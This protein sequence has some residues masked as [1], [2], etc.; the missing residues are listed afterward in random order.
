MPEVLIKIG[1]G[2]SYEDGDILC[3]FNRRRTRQCHM[4]C[5]CHPWKESV[6][7]DGLRPSDGLA[8]W[9]HKTC[10]QYRFERVN[11]HEVLRTDLITGETMLLGPKPNEDKQHIFVEEYLARRKRAA[12]PTGGPKKAI[13][14]EEGHE[15]W[16]GGQIDCSDSKL[17]IVWAK[18]AE[19]TG[20]LE[21]EEEFQ[22]WPMGR[23]DIRHHLAVRTVDFSDEEAS[24]MVRPAIEWEDWGRGIPRLDENEQQIIVAK[25]ALNIDWRREL[26]DDLQVLE[27]DVLDQDTPIGRDV[28]LPMNRLGHRSKEQPTQ[29][30]MGKMQDKELGGSVRWQR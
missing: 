19:K 15:I 20:R 5:V 6:T 26:L 10:Y 17:D 22:L 13:F 21:S 23:L 24:L 7:R 30:D 12:A 11:R 16:Y 14:G 8:E 28:I 9:M 4:E 18:I 1:A 3:A 29:A 27:A 25:R 2:A